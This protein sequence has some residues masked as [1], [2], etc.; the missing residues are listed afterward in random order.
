MRE[1]NMSTDVEPVTE[2]PPLHSLTDR[3]LLIEIAA[4]LRLV[5][6]VMRQL[7]GMGPGGMMR[8][9]LGK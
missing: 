6:D 7:Q 8:M 2:L 4:N 3:E 1:A 9:F 5:G